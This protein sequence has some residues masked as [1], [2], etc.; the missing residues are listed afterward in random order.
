M[1][2]LVIQY[3]TRTGLWGALFHFLPLNINIW[4]RNARGT[5]MYNIFDYK[6]IICPFLHISI[7]LNAPPCSFLIPSSLSPPPFFTLHSLS[8][9]SLPAA[10]SSNAH[11]RQCGATLAVGLKMQK[12][13]CEVAHTG[14]MLVWRLFLITNRRVKL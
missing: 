9:T 2:N 14:W 7:R 4:R 12:S 1:V 5:K 13:V 11:P 8:P 3:S 6:Y 10:I